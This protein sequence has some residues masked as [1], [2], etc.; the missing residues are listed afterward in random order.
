MPSLTTF[1]ASS[2]GLPHGA[3]LL[4]EAG[5]VWLHVLAD[6]SIALAYYAIPLSLI[7]FVRRRQDLAFHCMFWLFG[8]FIFAC[9]TTHLMEIW[10]L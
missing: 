2:P 10:T 7:Y 6:A 3:C 1:L 8:A 5:L 4:W 9:G